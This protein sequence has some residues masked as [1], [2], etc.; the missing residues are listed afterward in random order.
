[1]TGRQLK[2]FGTARR[3]ESPTPTCRNCAKPLGDGTTGAYCN[4]CFGLSVFLA[5]V[6]ETAWMADAICSQ[7]D[8]DAFFPDKGGTPQIAK[9]VCA[10]CPVVGECAAFAMAR[11]SLEGVWGGMTQRERQLARYANRRE[12][13]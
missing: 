1:M 9:D 3:P 7:T 10:R 5:D 2:H 4:A 11:P 6:A 8:P 13:A 12:A